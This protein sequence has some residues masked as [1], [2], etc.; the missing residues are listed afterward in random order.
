MGSRTCGGTA[1]GAPLAT[2]ILVLLLPAVLK[3]QHTGRLAG[4]NLQNPF[5][6]LQPGALSYI[7]HQVKS[8]ASGAALGFNTMKPIIQHL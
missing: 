5:C 7:C 1:D 2:V 6:R 3:H 4:L 8:V